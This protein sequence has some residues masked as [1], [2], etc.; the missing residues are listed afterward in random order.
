MKLYKYNNMYKK[1]ATLLFMVV[2]SVGAYAQGARSFK[3]NEVVVSNT[4]GLIDE[5]GAR[6]GWIEIANT[7]WST[8]NIRS[9]YLTT[10]KEVLNPY[11][12]APE[13]IALM[14]LIPKGDPRTDVGAQQ[15]VVFFADGRTNLGTFHTDFT[16]QPGQENWIAL[17]DGNGVTLLDSITVP[18]L[19][20][21]QSWARLYTK[22]KGYFFDTLQP[23][24]VTPNAPNKSAEAVQ[25]K[26]AEFKEK[27]PYG[28][29]MSI[30][31]M[32]VVFSCLACLYIFFRLFGIFVSSFNK[33]LSVFGVRKTYDVAMKA[34]NVAMQGTETKGVDM[35]IYAAVI[36]M[37]L[38]EHEN[39]VHDVEPGVITLHPEERSDWNAHNTT[40]RE[41]PKL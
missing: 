16:L 7:S 26:I 8:V 35:K 18:P 4:D 22:E 3:F 33:I 6:S 2:C 10:N 21:N 19:C 15:R 24:E 1:L 17:Y 39:D 28:I 12:S 36:A 14:S 13:R 20:C 27:D 41:W 5:Y 38:H 37:A 11:L 31:A 25:D 23:D 29:A 32:T 9:C 40:M 34:A 30:M